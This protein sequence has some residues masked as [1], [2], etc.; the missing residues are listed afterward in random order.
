MLYKVHCVHKLGC[1]KMDGWIYVQCKIYCMLEHQKWESIF[2]FIAV[3]LRGMVETSLFSLS[4]IYSH[5]CA[6][7]IMINMISSLAR[8][9][10]VF[11]FFCASYLKGLY[12]FGL[13]ETRFYDQAEKVAMEVR[14]SFAIISFVHNATTVSNRQ[15]VSRL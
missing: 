9:K 14:F 8:V 10:T 5:K 12:S 15:Q 4:F 1:C 3:V 11:L 6:L 13:L 2:M 7:Y